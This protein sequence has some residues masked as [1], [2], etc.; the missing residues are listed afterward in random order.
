MSIPLE[1]E[2]IAYAPTAYYHCSH[3]EFAW[4]EMDVTT[5]VHREQ[6]ESSLPADLLEEY[7]SLMQWVQETLQRYCDRV[8][9]RVT[10]A[11]S[12][13]G[14]WKSLRYRA[15]RYPAVI[16]NGQVCSSGKEAFDLAR[17]ELEKRLEQV[18]PA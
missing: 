14:V 12:L 13:Q 18:T 5:E 1:V 6:I 8:S 3:C 2:V 9:I 10:D 16:I 4:R 11:A 17:L 7:H 15:R